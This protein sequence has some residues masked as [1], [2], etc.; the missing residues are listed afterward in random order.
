VLAD[1]ISC[2]ATY[3]RT[4]ETFMSHIIAKTFQFLKNKK[5]R[6]DPAGLA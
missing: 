3:G 2:N 6:K 4:E 5:G 1:E